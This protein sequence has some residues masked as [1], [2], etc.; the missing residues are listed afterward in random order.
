MERVQ[1]INHSALPKSLSRGLD[2]T[3]LVQIDPTEPRTDLKGR[4]LLQ[5]GPFVMLVGRDGTLE[6]TADHI[7]MLDQ[8]ILGGAGCPLGGRD[9]YHAAE[10]VLAP[11]RLR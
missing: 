5:V 9:R 7:T 1:W 11:D 10:S 8:A 6:G 2:A 3:S 4:I